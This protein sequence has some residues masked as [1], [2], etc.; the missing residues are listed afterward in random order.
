MYSQFQG[1][2][3]AYISV[4][5]STATTLLY[6]TFFP[7]SGSVYVDN[8]DVIAPFR[9]WLSGNTRGWHSAHSQRSTKHARY[10]LSGLSDL[11]ADS[12]IYSSYFGGGGQVDLMELHVADSQRVLLTGAPTSGN[13]PVTPHAFDTTR[14]GWKSFA[15]W[16][17]LPDSVLFSTLLGSP[18]LVGRTSMSKATAIDPATGNIWLGGRTESPDFPCTADAV[19]S[20][21]TDPIGQEY[22]DGFVACFSP[23]LDSLLYGSYIGG[24]D[25]DIVTALAFE[26]SQRLWIGGYTASWDY[27]VTA[28]AFKGGLWGNDDGCYALLTLPV[29][30]DTGDTSTTHTPL[31]LF[32]SAFSLSAFPNPF[33]STTEI[34]YALP[35]AGHVALKV[36][37]LLGREVGVLVDAVMVAGE[38]RVA[39]DARGIASGI[40]F[41]RLASGEMRVTR[42]VLLVR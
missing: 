29:P 24:G 2:E 23:D 14:G 33:N 6:S 30:P 4:F 11:A 27:P 9:V 10:G 40:Y 28:G 16:L 35:R 3:P 18:S 31:S 19:D 21:Y 26:N 37:D 17:L 39:F 25:R 22:G 20:L 12:L 13:F 15:T 38:Q 32:P 8:I 5:D 34:R 42:K 1:N 7:S 36:Y 41:V